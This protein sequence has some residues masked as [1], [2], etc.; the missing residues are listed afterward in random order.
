MLDRRDPERWRDIEDRAQHYH[1]AFE[2]GR[3]SPSVY[4]AWL[5]TLGFRGREIETEVSLHYPSKGPL[6]GAT[7]FR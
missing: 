5:Y 4:R 6:I 2:S 1:A 3:M 7:Q